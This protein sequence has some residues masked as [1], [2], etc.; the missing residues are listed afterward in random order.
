ML[1]S[2][3]MDGGFQRCETF[4]L[5]EDR[6]IIK[7]TE[8][9]T[10]PSQKGAAWIWTSGM[11]GL[12]Q[13]AAACQ[14]SGWR[15]TSGPGDLWSLDTLIYRSYQRTLQKQQTS[16]NIGFVTLK[17]CFSACNMEQPSLLQIPTEVLNVTYRRKS[18]QKGEEPVKS[19]GQ[20]GH[21]LTTAIWP[22]D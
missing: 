12:P 11:E 4:W 16:F 22:K 5:A 14:G 7:A 19:T 13:C 18:F 3:E 15:L 6:T 9:I 17:R 8:I 20:Y 1:H 10:L 2:Y 21:V